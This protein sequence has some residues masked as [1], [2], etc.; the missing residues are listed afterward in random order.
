MK[1]NV[2]HRRSNRTGPSNDDEFLPFF[3]SQWRYLKSLVMD[4][5]INLETSKK[6]IDLLIAIQQRDTAEGRLGLAVTYEIYNAFYHLHKLDR[7]SNTEGAALQSVFA[8]ALQR[9]VNHLHDIH[10]HLEGGPSPSY[11]AT[12]EYFSLPGVIASYRNDIAHG[13][14]PSVDNMVDAI[15]EIRKAVINNYWKPFNGYGATNPRVEGGKE[16]LFADFSRKCRIFFEA[17]SPHPQTEEEETSLRDMTLRLI[18][19]DFHHFARSFFSTS[20]AIKDEDGYC[21]KSLP[22]PVPYSEIE[23]WERLERFIGVIYPP[24][25]ETGNMF[26]FCI[27]GFQSIEDAK[28]GMDKERKAKFFYACAE[29][30]IKKHYCFSINETTHLLNWEERINPPKRIFFD[31]IPKDEKNIDRIRITGELNKLVE[32]LRAAEV[33]ENTNEDGVSPAK[34]DPSKPWGKFVLNKYKDY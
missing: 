9:S 29:K 16:D 6:I 34:V 15:A 28:S 2:P 20:F 32:E 1:R 14:Y 31:M 26:F 24:L 7:N 5:S 19:N 22:S 27:H 10:G 13:N 17:A 3:P 8:C 25:K 30:I 23:V 18:N 11:R 21:F 4:D 33:E 12:M